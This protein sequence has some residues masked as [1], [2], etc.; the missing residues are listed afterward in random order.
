MKAI[1]LGRQQINFREMSSLA[2]K[3]YNDVEQKPV[4]L[5]KGKQFLSYSFWNIKQDQNRR[6]R[7]M[8]RFCPGVLTDILSLLQ[9]SLVWLMKLFRKRMKEILFL[10]VRSGNSTEIFSPVLG[11]ETREIQRCLE[12]QVALC[13]S[14]YVS[15]CISFSA[16]MYISLCESVCICVYLCM[17]LC[18][19]VCVHERVCVC[20][21]VCT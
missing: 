5:Q 14:L 4:W 15:V 9:F 18:A 21:C 12:F 13:V 7:S 1:F 20:I 10:F 17:C 16:C 2:W 6:Q 19:F 3:E 8:T 11:D